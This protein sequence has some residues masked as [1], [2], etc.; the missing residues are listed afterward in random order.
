MALA[1]RGNGA[2]ARTAVMRESPGQPGN[3]SETFRI[4]GSLGTFSEDRCFAAER[5]DFARIDLHDLPTPT[6]QDVNVADIRDPL[7]GDVTRALERAMN[8]DAGDADLQHLDFNPR[9]HGGSHPYLVHEF[10]EAAAAER[11]PAINI[12][13]AARCMAMGIATHQ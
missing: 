9:R 4:V 10:V 7:P 13:E 6:W 2:T 11:Q 8:K 12:R 5:P 1:K 3:E